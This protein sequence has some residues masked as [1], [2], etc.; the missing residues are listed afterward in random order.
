MPFYELDRE[1]EQPDAGE[2]THISEDLRANRQKLIFAR[3]ERSAEDQ[4]ICAA[5]LKPLEAQPEVN[6]GV[7]K[8]CSS[9]AERTHDQE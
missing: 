2:Q 1:P 5:E 6:K 7:V 9:E 8:M 4:P 3:L